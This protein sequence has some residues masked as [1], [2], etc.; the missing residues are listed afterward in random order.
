[1][2]THLAKDKLVINGHT[3]TA[4]PISNIHEINTFLDIA[5]TCERMDQNKIL[6][7]GSHSPFSNLHHSPFR[8]NNTMYNCAEQYIQSGKAALFNDDVAHA[9]IMQETNSY[10]HWGTGLHLQDRK[11]MNNSLWINKSGGIM[12]EILNDVRKSLRDK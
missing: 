5:S 12:S 10:A 8:V 11:A 4:A 3:F 7:L 2:K 1:M 9:K 6:F